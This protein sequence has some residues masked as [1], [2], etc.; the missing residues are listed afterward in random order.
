MTNQLKLFYAHFRKAPPSSNKS[1]MLR[2]GVLMVFHI[3]PLYSILVRESQKINTGHPERRP[4]VPDAPASAGAVDDGPEYATQEQ[5]LANSLPGGSPKMLK[6]QSSASLDT[7][8][9]A[10]EGCL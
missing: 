1:V 6:R 7:A 4:S 10:K 8:G 9:I 5:N 3:E 2:I